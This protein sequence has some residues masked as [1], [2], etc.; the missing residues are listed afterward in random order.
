MSPGGQVLE[1]RP[2]LDKHSVECHSTAAQ[3]TKGLKKMNISEWMGTA[4]NWDDWRSL[5]FGLRTVVDG[6]RLK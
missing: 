6:S 5:T 2:R 4:Q 1:L 3:I